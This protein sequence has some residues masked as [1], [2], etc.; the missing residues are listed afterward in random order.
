MP[1]R[2]NLDAE[3]PSLRD[4]LD[5]A[6]Q[7]DDVNAADLT[8]DQVALLNLKRVIDLKDQAGDLGGGKECFIC[9]TGA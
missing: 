6:S 9:G 8:I 4:L 3:N 5:Q 2:I 7:W 1:N